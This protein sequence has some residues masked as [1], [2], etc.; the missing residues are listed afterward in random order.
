MDETTRFD[1]P[2]FTNEEREK[3]ILLEKKSYI[4]EIKIIVPRLFSDEGSLKQISRGQPRNK[5]HSKQTISIGG[6]EN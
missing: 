1:F 6:F 4:E 5:G 2:V 3:A